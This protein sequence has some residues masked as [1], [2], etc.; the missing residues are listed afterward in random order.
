MQLPDDEE[1]E[2]SNGEAA[3]AG[4]SNRVQSSL[5]FTKPN[6]YYEATM[7]SNLFSGFWH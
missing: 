2:A 5:G 3:A 1:Q 4:H 6:G 7:H